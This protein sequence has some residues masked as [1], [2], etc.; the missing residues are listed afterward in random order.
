MNVKKAIKNIVSLGMGVTMVGATIMGAMAATLSQYPEPFTKDGSF[1][2]LMVVGAAAQPTDIIGVTDIATS[3]QYATKKVVSTTTTSSVSVSEGVKL[4]KTG[5]NLYY[6]LSLHD[7]QDTELDNSDLPVILAD[8]TF[9]DNEGTNKATYDYTQKLTIDNNSDATRVVY[10][11]D[12]TRAPDAGLY[13]HLTDTSNKYAYQ[14]GLEFTTAV[15]YDNSTSTDAKNDLK[16][17][18]LD[19]MGQTYTITDV[20]V[21]S[22]K[23]NKITMLAGKTTQTIAV[24]SPV[25]VNVDGTDYDVEVLGVTNDNTKC[26]LSINSVVSTIDVDNTE[27]VSGIEIGVTDAAHF[28]GGS[29]SCQVNIG[30]NKLILED[31]QQ[32]SV[33]DVDQDGSKVTLNFDA[34]DKSKWT[35]FTIQ[36]QPQNDVYLA[37]GE[38][39]TDP[40]FGA[41]K[42]V[43]GGD[44]ADR[45]DIKLVRTGDE[46]SLT[47]NNY[48]GKETELNWYL[49]T[50]NNVRLAFGNDPIN[51]RIYLEGDKCVPASGSTIED[52][53]G[54]RF[55]AVTNSGVAHVV[56]IKN[57]DLTNNKID[58]KDLTYSAEDKDN[59]YHPS[60]NISGTGMT[61]SSI[62]LSG[63]GIIKLTINETNGI[64]FD[65]VN[66][67]SLGGPG[68]FYTENEAIMTVIDSMANTT[69]AAIAT[70]QEKHDDA[71]NTTSYSV[72]NY[73]NTT[74]SLKAAYDSSNS[75]IDLSYAVADT[76]FGRK[77]L[78]D[79]DSDNKRQ[80]TYWGSL[81]S[82]D[83]NNND[84]VLVQYPKA[85][86]YVDAFIAPIT[87]TSSTSEV[88]GL[89]EVVAIGPGATKLDSEISDYKAQNLIVVGGP[90][91][92]TVAAALM[93][94]PTNC[95]QD[96]E[97]GKAMIKLFNHD[98][99]KVAL[100]VAGY[101]A[102]DTR[103]AAMWMNQY[104]QHSSTLKQ[105]NTENKSIE[106]A[107][108]NLNS[109][110]P[111]VK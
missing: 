37:S 27:T 91:V 33:N 39:W 105:A 108:A 24:G 74:I 103:A 46:A 21:S 2:A 22:G 76:G 32:V 93:G 14:Y 30:A 80:M 47:F 10:E 73:V 36:A 26:Q 11:Q 55:L 51:E 54:A 4:E 58:F 68:S 110:T 70:I 34:S 17:N 83:S 16:T 81:I 69:A 41:F 63:V 28:E 6:G 1:N 19:I 57:V 84:E 95:A 20:T 90:C 8:G 15:D 60:V 77:D 52:C 53:E 106:L 67:G 72:P 94:N 65:D 107:V 7:M 111:L 99:G 109:V 13:L 71:L 61:N 66:L 92:N 98:N 97:Q 89:S 87:A 96:F 62:S 48:D 25:T 104:S 40:V 82:Y 85:R 75:E 5:S 44:H 42:F 38:S 9:D 78:S 100:L 18:S 31:G 49:N 35:G 56:E 50:S 12:D 88:S 102:Q 86:A 23:I 45:E 59:T 3:L 101:S 64:N 29:D 43:M 79:S